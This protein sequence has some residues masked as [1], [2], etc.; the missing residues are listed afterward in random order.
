MAAMK[1]LI[2]LPEHIHAFSLISLGYSNETP[3][4]ANRFDL[5]RIHH[6]KW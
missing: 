1:N 2:H 5:S 4:A 6:D 3:T